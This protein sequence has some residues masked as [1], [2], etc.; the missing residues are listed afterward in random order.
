M[1]GIGFQLR[2][3]IGKGSLAGTV[4]AMVSG[5]FIV[6]GPWILSI[7]SMFLIRFSFL[8]A[9]FAYAD[10]FQASVI[11]SY[12]LSLCLFSG[13]HHLFIRLVSDLCWAE[14]TGEASGWL[15]LFLVGIV[16]C[17]ALVAAP[18]VVLSHF[19][20]GADE[21]L[22]KIGLVLFFVSVNCMWIALL[23]SSLLRRYKAVL[24][25]FALGFGLSAA[26]T[27]ALS[28]FL[29]LGGALLG[30]AI[31]HFSIV[32]ALLVLVLRQNPP[33]RPVSALTTFF[34]Y[35]RKFRWLVYSGFFFY[36]G[37]WLDK[38]FFWITRGSNVADT[39]FR[40]Y[41][42]Y[43]YSV[44]LAGLSV[45]PGLVY[46]IVFSE[47]RLYTNLRRFLY[48]L[49]RG[50]WQAIFQS[51]K[52][53]VSGLRSE[54][55]AQMTLQ[56]FF[57]ALVFFFVRFVFSTGLEPVGLYLAIGAAFFQFL[58]LSVVCFLYYFEFYGLAFMCTGAFFLINGLVGSLVYLALPTLPPGVSH[59]A[60]AL[61]SSILGYCL[62]DRSVKKLD[63]IIFLRMI[64]A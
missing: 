35:S 8:K 20:L 47:T 2:R 21:A 15:I 51:K 11:Y 64:K 27:V 10:V 56:L 44:Y 13:L 54:L 40:L 23:F 12:S 57:S 24:A 26:L 53:L 29:G 39:P 18:I 46:F 32:A 61:F 38:F 52:R 19:S 14:K 36:C 62:L 37:Q 31:G 45:I 4:S 25:V 55:F 58:L 59:L 33:E 22:F 5:V 60:A 1:A 28:R 30:L 9:D 41:E 42:T 43:D 63:R 49:S 17:S 50:T 48:N 34:T 3:V 7:L 6:A 16:L